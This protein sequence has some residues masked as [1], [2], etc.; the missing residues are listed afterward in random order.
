MMDSDAPLITPQDPTIRRSPS[1]ESTNL[2]ERNA[3]PSTFGLWWREGLASLVT[4][5]MMG[6]VVGTILPHQDKPLPEWPYWISINTV[7]LIYFII[8]KAVMA[9]VLSKGLG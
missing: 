1:S 7:V 4:L 2:A 5:A 3:Y 6:A 8:L 9:C